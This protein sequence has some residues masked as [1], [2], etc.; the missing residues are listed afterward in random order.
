MGVEKH[1]Y[2][3]SGTKVM[4]KRKEGNEVKGSLCECMGGVKWWEGVVAKMIREN[5]SV[6]EILMQS[7]AQLYRALGQ[8]SSSRRNSKCKSPETRSRKAFL[9]S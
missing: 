2:H 7:R 6:M 5:L 4:K 3:D 9:D 1:K 8:S